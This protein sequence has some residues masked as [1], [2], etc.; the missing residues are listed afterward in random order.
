MLFLCGVGR[1]TQ[2]GRTNNASHISFGLFDFYPLQIHSSCS[3]GNAQDA[4]FC[5]GGK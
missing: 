5:M 2:V 3:D 4:R 1:N